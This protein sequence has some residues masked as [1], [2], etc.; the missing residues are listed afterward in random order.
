M[1][2]VNT[3]FSRVWVRRLAQFLLG[4]VLSHL[5]VVGLSPY[6]YDSSVARALFDVLIFPAT[7]TGMLLGSGYASVMTW[8]WGACF[9]RAC[10]RCVL[11]FDCDGDWVGVG[12]SGRSGKIRNKNLHL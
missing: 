2:A 5:S 1:L 7:V 4:A 8:G 6:V 9:E 12:M 10:C 3:I 11:G